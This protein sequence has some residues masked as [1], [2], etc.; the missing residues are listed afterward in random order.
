MT[1]RVA[2]RSSSAL[3]A[4]FVLETQKPDLGISS[5]SGVQYGYLLLTS[6]GERSIL[7][8]VLSFVTDSGLFYTDAITGKLLLAEG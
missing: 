4:G 5:I 2:A 6:A 8:P 3:I 1:T 7:R